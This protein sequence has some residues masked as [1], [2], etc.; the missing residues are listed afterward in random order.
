LVDGYGVVK[1]NVWKKVADA[2]LRQLLDVVGVG[3][4]TK[5]HFLGRQF[6]R[7][8]ANAPARPEVDM[9]F[10]LFLHRKIPP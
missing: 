6:D 1:P 7:K 4:P 9:A 2:M 3:Q 10:Q 5:D 8:V